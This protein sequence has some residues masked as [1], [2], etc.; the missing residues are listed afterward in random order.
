MPKHPPYDPASGK[1][2]KLSRSGL[3]LLHD[4]PRCFYLDKR[5]GIGRPGGFPFNINSAVDTLL[6]R[7]FDFHRDRGEPHPLMTE[8][9]VDAIPF[10]HADLSTWRHNFTGVRHLHE[11][12]GFLVS[13]AVDDVWVNP[14]GEL[15]VVD[16]KATAK[17]ADITS[18][19][20]E[21]HGSYKRQFEVYQWLL[22]RNGFRVSDRAYWVY[23]NGDTTADRFDRVVRFRMTVIPYDGDDSWV[24]SRVIHAKECLDADAP[25]PAA[26][27]CQ[28]CGFARDAA[29]PTRRSGKAEASRA[30]PVSAGTPHHR[31]VGDT[32]DGAADR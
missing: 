2:F 12:T 19:D 24:D 25:P 7:E 18:L 22:R 16:Y 29:T 28:W 30:A 27:A 23:A 1:P 9:G 5:L 20:A 32:P 21:W 31:G 14:S 11:P 17:K 4:C 3:E 15:I 6:K 13:G 10:A 8:F 26:E